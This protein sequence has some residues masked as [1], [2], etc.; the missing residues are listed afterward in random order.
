MDK[1]K[2]QIYLTMGIVIGVIYLGCVWV[3]LHYA[4][5]QDETGFYGQE[6][7]DAVFRDI[8]IQPFAIFPFPVISLLYI[9]LVTLCVAVIVYSFILN[10]K[11]KRA[12]NPDTV[13]G[14]AKWLDGKAL[15]EYNMKFTEPFDKITHE[16]KNN[17]IL[18]RDLFMSLD[19]RGIGDHN[20]HNSRN[21][22]VL[23]IG[24]SGAGKSF[25]LVGPNLMQAGTCS[26]IVTDP[27]GELYRNYSWFLEKEG[28][29]IKCF[30]LSHMERGN[31][32]NPF[33]YIHS[34]KDIEVLVNTLISNTNPPEKTGGDPFWEKSETALLLALIAYLY[35][36][37]TEAD[38]NFST[39]MRLL[40][41]AEIDEN[42]SSAE[43]PLD[44]LFNELAEKDPSSFAYKQYRTFKM[45]AGKTLKSILISAAVRLQ[46][47]DLEDVANLTDTDDIDLDSV[48]DEKTALFVIIPTGDKTFNFLATLMYSQLFQR[49]Y[50]YCENTAIYSQVVYNQE[51]EVIRTFRAEN[52]EAS[53]S[54][55]K[56]L[57][58]E[59]LNKAKDAT[60]K[61]EK[62]YGLFMIRAK[63]GTSLG[64]S[65]LKER[66]EEML[67]SM[68]HGYVKQLGKARLPI[69]V[70]FLMDEFAN[71]GKPA[72]FQELVATIRKYEISVMII[73]QSLQQMKN[74]F[75][76][77]WEAIS[78]NCDNAIYLGGGADTVT[79]EWISK[80]LGKETRVVLGT[81]YN[82]NSGSTSYNRQGEDLFAPAQLRT[83]D[84]RD[85]IVIQKS[86]QAYKGAKY[87]ATKHPNWK[88][89]DG[90]HQYFFNAD[91]Q[92]DLYLEYVRA[93]GGK[94]SKKGESKHGVVIMTPEMKKVLD[95][96]RNIGAKER[97]EEIKNN[98]GADGKPLISSPTDV[99]A[100]GTGSMKNHIKAQTMQDIKETT[101]SFV[102]DNDNCPY[103]E[104]DFDFVSE[105]AIEN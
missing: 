35:H 103:D 16:G 80:L 21:M 87:N 77:E 25:G 100:E 32:Y 63:D 104:A 42:D 41:A 28:Y 45:G 68:R 83:M 57:A 73:L 62:K 66:A 89:C 1:K 60:V 24:G 10:A 101:S 19:N 22:N 102:D 56:K 92:R 76:K 59:F 84:E 55:A 72:N 58:E 31:H 15:D 2:K 54:Q 53:N 88:Y 47:F 86:L 4:I 33:R 23:A 97:A 3:Y 46:Q 93:G 13:H 90:S 8:K 82:G 79:A 91:R 20:N 26:F 17:M 18:S 81:S 69:H 99:N 30:N 27:S 48:G 98:R 65:T 12:Y 14:D 37:G 96:L 7:W 94:V 11:N 39:V 40:R 44:Q 51:G 85:C 6:L 52:Q 61:E 50:T 75:E 34:D 74:L 43:S 78:G 29:R 70:R 9:F 64:Y 49:F 5:V 36:E 38:K 105:K 95:E 71:T 67:E